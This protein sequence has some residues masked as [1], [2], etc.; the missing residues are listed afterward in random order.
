MN[1]LLEVCLTLSP[2]PCIW[3]EEVSSWNASGRCSF[4]L[5]LLWVTLERPLH[6]KE[7]IKHF[8]SPEEWSYMNSAKLQGVPTIFLALC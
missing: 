1:F 6:Y 3:E 5:E 8:L 4:Y 7:L 2:G